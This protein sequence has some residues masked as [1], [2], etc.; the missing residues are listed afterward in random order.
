MPAG[1][2][3]LRLVKMSVTSREWNRT[4]YTRLHPFNPYFM[5]EDTSFTHRRDRFFESVIRVIH[6]VT[7]VTRNP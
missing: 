3:R 4:V 6:S 7:C 1:T 5:S 2:P